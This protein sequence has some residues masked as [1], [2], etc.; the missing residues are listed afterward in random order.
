VANV[1]RRDVSSFLALAARIP[2][3]PEVE[4]Y[5]LADANRALMELKQRNIRGAKVLVM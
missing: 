1:T 5:A 3:I 4:T 2:I